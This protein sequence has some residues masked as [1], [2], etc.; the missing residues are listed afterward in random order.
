MLNDANGLPSEHVG[1]LLDGH[2]DSGA[3]VLY[4]GTSKG[5]AVSHGGDFAL[6]AGAPVGAVTLIYE[7]GAGSERELWVAVFGA[8]V[9]RYA[10]GAWTVFR[11][12]DGVPDERIRSMAQTTAE[13]GARTTWLAS[14]T[15]LLRFDGRRFV[16]VLADALP[17]P[18]VWSLL[19]EP[20]HGPTHT[21]WIGVDGGLARMRMAGFRTFAGE[22]ATKS[23][24][25]M[26]VTQEGGREVL[27]LGTRGGGLQRF[28]GENWT[29]PTG[30]DAP[31]D[32]TVYAITELEEERGKRTLWVG[33][34]GGDLA[35]EEGGAW[36]TQLSAISTV[37][38]L[39]AFA[40]DDAGAQILD[41]ATGNKGIYRRARGAWTHIDMTAGLPTNEVFDVA[42]TRAGPGAPPVLWVATDGAGIVRREESG[43]WTHFDRQSSAVLSDSVLALHVVH[44]AV[45][46]RDLALWAGTQ[47]GGASVLDLRDPNARFV[48]F[49]ERSRPA[50]PNDTVYAVKH[51]RR[52]RV[53]LFT[54]KG[55][56]RL[57]PRA[58]ASGSDDAPF[59]IRTFTIEDGLPAN[60]CNSGAAYVDDRGR[61]W[62]GTVSGVAFFDAASDVRDDAVP[63][64]D[65]VPRLE[66]TN[67]RLL[68]GARLPYDT[69]G[70]AFDYVL[71]RLF[72]GQETVYRT[73]LGGL[74][75]TP[76]PWTLDARHAYPTLPEGSYVFRVWARDFEGREA[77]PAAVAFEVRPPPWLTWWAVTACTPS[78]SARGPT[79]SRATASIRSSAGT[80]CSKRASRSAPR[81]S[82]GRSTSSPSRSRAPARRRT[83]PAGPTAPR[84]SSSRR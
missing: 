37:R 45:S 52:G 53:F 14:D 12:A 44:D 74:E 63:A 39:H 23:A 33:T 73:Q 57:T 66:R 26:Q 1:A 25:A 10:R 78:R 22:A 2:D 30:G 34:P 21:L 5:L 7:S 29:R 40:G 76:G 68:P 19:P 9:A 18:T 47:G 8:G 4:A 50:L 64:I 13:D 84:A 56:A 49:T 42:E 6:A 80:R 81:H 17:S 58:T 69:S 62:A 46:G 60:E 27:W 54:N 3:A 31:F 41:V 16:R 15:G 36:T 61:I 72:R 38:Q 79:R 28:D 55:V 24:Y 20:T 48:T 59:T 32:D 71:P 43:A 67:E 35:R 82:D 51:D 83:T 70:V 77:G 11:L 65:L 75:P